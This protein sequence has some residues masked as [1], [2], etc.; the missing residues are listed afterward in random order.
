MTVTW[1]F[2]SMFQHLFLDNGSTVD[3]YMY[4][5]PVIRH[6]VPYTYGQVYSSDLELG[7]VKYD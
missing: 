1:T 3:G 5:Y 6:I 7:V 4:A 2:L